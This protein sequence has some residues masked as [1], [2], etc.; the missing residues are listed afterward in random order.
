MKKYFNLFLIGLFSVFMISCSDDNNSVADGDTYS[1]VYD[2]TDNF[3]Y[4]D[5]IDAYAIS[6]TFNQPIPNSDVVLVYRQSSVSNGNPVWKLNP[7]TLYLNEGELDYSFDFT[8]NDVYITADGTM[9]FA[10]QNATFLNSYLNNQKFRI[11]IVPA[12][13]ARTK[14]PLSMEYNDVIKRYNINDAHVTTLK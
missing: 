4:D 13:F 3:A 2:I 7:Y 9:N 14:E 5:K 8:K 11:V 6:R 1:V 10:N 12:S